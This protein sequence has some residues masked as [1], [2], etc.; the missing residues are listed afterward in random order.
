MSRVTGDAKSHGNN[1]KKKKIGRR[2]GHDLSKGLFLCILD[3]CILDPESHAKYPWPNKFQSSWRSEPQGH[4][5]QVATQ[6]C[7]LIMDRSVEIC[8]VLYLNAFS[9]CSEC[10]YVYLC[11]YLWFFVLQIHSV[12]YSLTG[13]C[14][15]LSS[16]IKG[17][18]RAYRDIKTLLSF[19]SG[20]STTSFSSV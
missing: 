15:F 16:D 3:P 9:R 14:C 20:S 13:M 19:S 11:N 10:V 18:K 6:A 2:R 17:H 1:S 7:R 8:V 5:S 12:L 4:A